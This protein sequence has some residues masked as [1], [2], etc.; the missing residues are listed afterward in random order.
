MSAHGQGPPRS[1]V[2]DAM[3]AIVARY[4]AVGDPTTFLIGERFLGSEGA[5]GRI[6]LVRGDGK[7]VG[8]PGKINDGNVD[9][10][11]QSFTAYVWAAEDTDDIVRYAAL[12]AMLDRLVNACRA[13]IPGRCEIGTFNPSITPSLVSFGEDMQ[14]VITY[15]RGVPRDG[16]IFAVP[17]TPVSPPDPMR[18]NGD[19]GTTFTLDA[20]SVATR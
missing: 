3:A 16:A 7:A 18:P 12:D 2:A 10:L 9:R 8:G 6:I 13:T 17:A 11:A 15:S 4:L 5:P 19:L 1:T 20:S 14:V